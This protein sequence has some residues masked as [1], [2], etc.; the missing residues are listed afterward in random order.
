MK[1]SVIV[2]N[3]NENENDGGIGDNKIKLW[4]QLTKNIEIFNYS[5]VQGTIDS[6]ICMCGYTYTHA[7]NVLY[8]YLDSLPKIKASQRGFLWLLLCQKQHIRGVCP[9]HGCSGFICLKSLEVFSP[10]T[11]IY[12]IFK[13]MI[14]TDCTTESLNFLHD[15]DC[16]ITGHKYSQY[17]C[18]QQ[19]R[20]KF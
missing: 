17:I 9:V 11:L 20:T 4:Q 16:Q 6:L 12:L 2:N 19:Q 15:F 7:Y 1:D 8:I 13:P 14:T 18:D 3:H 10:V 5:Q